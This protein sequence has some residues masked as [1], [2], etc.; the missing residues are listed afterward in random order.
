MC[1]YIS[2]EPN[3]NESHSEATE[4]NYDNTQNKKRNIT[5]ILTKHTLQ[6]KRQKNR[7]QGKIF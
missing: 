4:K 2:N 1:N 6:K 3:E 7:L 5:K